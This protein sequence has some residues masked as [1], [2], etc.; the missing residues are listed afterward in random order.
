MSLTL[1][2]DSINNT[3]AA[4][5]ESRYHFII[6]IQVFWLGCKVTSFTWTFYNLLVNFQ[7][8]TVMNTKISIY[9]LP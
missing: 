1:I 4:L 5:A 2:E 3:E 8:E 9:I 6:T 7:T